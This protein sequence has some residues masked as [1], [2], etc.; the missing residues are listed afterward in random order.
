MSFLGGLFGS[1]NIT[2]SDTGSEYKTNFSYVGVGIFLVLVLDVSIIGILA[3]SD[4][5]LEGIMIIQ[6]ILLLIYG[7]IAGVTAY[8]SR[9]YFRDDLFDMLALLTNHQVNTAQAAASMFG[10]TGSLLG[11]YG[12]LFSSAR[13]DS[14]NE[15]E[16]QAEVK[17]LHGMLEYLIE[18][19]QSGGRTNVREVFDQNPTVKTN[20]PLVTFDDEQP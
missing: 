1:R 13:K 8:L 15:A 14:M 7:L 12:R 17:R 6:F 10:N 2:Q 3:F 5:T 18:Q 11:D 20:V 19:N 9:G 4:Y 16:L